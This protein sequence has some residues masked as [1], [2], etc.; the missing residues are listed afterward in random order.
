MWDEV[1]IEKII[2]EKAL[3]QD[4]YAYA[5][6]LIY[7]IKKGAKPKPKAFTIKE[8]NFTTISY[9]DVEY[10]EDGWADATKFAPERFDIVV[11]HTMDGKEANGWY[12]GGD[13]FSHRLGDKIKVKKWKRSDEV[14]VGG[15][16]DVGGV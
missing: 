8:V 4:T 9:D 3:I 14:F 1:P 5:R 16:K 15:P 13:W 2:S 6:R 11:L 7:S 12:K 10:D